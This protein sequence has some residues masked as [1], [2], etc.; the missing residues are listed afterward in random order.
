MCRKNVF[1]LAPIPIAGK[2]IWIRP[3]GRVAFIFG[4]DREGLFEHFYRSNILIFLPILGW[5]YFC[6]ILK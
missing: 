1:A 2:H 6:G 3:F 5:K 4:P